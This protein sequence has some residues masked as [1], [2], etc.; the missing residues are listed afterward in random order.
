MFFGAGGPDSTTAPEE[1]NNTTTLGK[2]QPSFGDPATTP[3][4]PPG[5]LS[6]IS[7]TVAGFET[8]IGAKLVE[9][10]QLL[11]LEGL[12]VAAARMLRAISRVSSMRVG[13]HARDAAKH[14]FESRAKVRHGLWGTHNP[15][16]GSINPDF[17]V[18]W[19]LQGALFKCS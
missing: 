9:S 12:L 15:S 13:A 6:T 11:G 14:F 17:G 8:F 3:R 19:E 10:Q 4:A 5:G 1:N 7:T 2:L 18:F 16:T